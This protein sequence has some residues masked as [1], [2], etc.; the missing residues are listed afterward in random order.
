MDET[1][2]PNWGTNWTFTPNASILT[3]D[4]GWLTVDVEFNSPL[5]KN[6]EFTGT[7]KVVNV[8][9]SGDYHE[10]DI[11]CKNPTRMILFNPILMKILKHF[12]LLERILNL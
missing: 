9:N 7:I 5:D 8:A 3:T 2:V 1:T 11:I 4:M 12:P 10:I 6:K